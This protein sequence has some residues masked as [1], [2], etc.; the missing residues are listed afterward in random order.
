MR[1]SEITRGTHEQPAE[2]S[3][4]PWK[5]QMH[6]A[7]EAFGNRYPEGYSNDDIPNEALDPMIGAIVAAAKMGIPFREAMNEWYGRFSCATEAM[8][9]LSRPFQVPKLSTRFLLQLVMRLCDAVQEQ[10]H[11]AHA[12][13]QL[14]GETQNRINS[15]VV[16]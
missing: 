11:P 8:R 13:S 6:A 12:V 5:Q 7:I 9:D 1:D 2:E 16:V 15:V 10:H 4:A 3:V 14:T